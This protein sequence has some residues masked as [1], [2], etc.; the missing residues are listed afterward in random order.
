MSQKPPAEHHALLNSFFY[1]YYSLLPNFDNQKPE[2]KP[3]AILSTEWQK[4]ELS[5]F[6]SYCNFQVGIKEADKDVKAMRDGV[7][8]RRLWFAGEHTSPF[9]ELGTAA[10]AYLSGEGVAVRISGVYGK[11][12]KIE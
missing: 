8:E 3:K 10:G 11:D 7:P 1:P 2:C 5:G 6:G 4:D 9:E 12:V